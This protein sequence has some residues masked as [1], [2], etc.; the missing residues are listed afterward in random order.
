LC[1]DWFAQNISADGK[2]AQYN[3]SSSDL[4]SKDV[5]I[6]DVRPEAFKKMLTV[7]VAVICCAVV[8]VL[9][10][11]FFSCGLVCGAGHLHR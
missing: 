5:V 4:E 2:A 10:L 9:H 1:A 11:I 8:C 3:T 6:E 7:C